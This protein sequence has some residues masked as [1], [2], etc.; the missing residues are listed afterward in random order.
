MI[1]FLV[2]LTASSTNDITASVGGIFSDLRYII[3]LLV[4]IPFALWVMGWLINL[5]RDI[6]YSRRQN[7]LFQKEL[8]ILKKA[9]YSITELPE[10]PEVLEA[11]KYFKKQGYK[12]EKQ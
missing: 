10:D 1:T 9:G 12:L 7:A 8:A 3:A 11:A 6:I 2:P 4:A 5:L